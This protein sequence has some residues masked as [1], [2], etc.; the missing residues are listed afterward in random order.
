MPNWVMTSVPA[1]V[2]ATS[3][4]LIWVDGVRSSNESNNPE[5]QQYILAIEE[6]CDLF[7]KS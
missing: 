6:L 4:R 3:L 7:R 2:S 5:K 1:K